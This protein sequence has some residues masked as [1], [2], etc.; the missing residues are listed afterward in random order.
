MLAYNNMLIALVKKARSA[1]STLRVA[2][3]YTNERLSAAAG[4][5][6]LSFFGTGIE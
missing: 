3:L 5:K 6:K 2:K 1:V 4:V